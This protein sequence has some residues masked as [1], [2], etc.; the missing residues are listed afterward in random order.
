[1]NLCVKDGSDIC[2][3]GE[4]VTVA[5]R[6]SRAQPDPCVNRGHAQKT[7]IHLYYMIKR[8]NFAKNMFP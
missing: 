7:K 4:A 2:S 8:I 3:H 6:R 1:M 5:I